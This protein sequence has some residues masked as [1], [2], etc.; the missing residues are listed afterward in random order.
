M[1]REAIAKLAAFQDIT[2]DE[3]AASMNEIMSGEATT[4]Q[5]GAFLA[6]MRMKGETS[7]EIIGCAR[8]MRE[9]AEPVR[10]TT[11]AI[12][13]VGTGGDGSNTFN[14][15]TCAAF[16]VAAAGMPVAKHG[17]RA[18]SSRC[19]SADGLEQLGGNIGLLPAQASECFARTGLCF[20]FAPVYHL[21]MKYAAAPR[22]ELG[23]RTIFNIL[24]PLANPAAAQYQL[25]G[26]CDDKLV[27]PMAQVLLDLG[28]RAAL[29]VHGH[30]GLDEISLSAPTTVCEVR[31]G[32]LNGYIIH[33]EQFGLQKAPL[34]EIVG[35]DAALNAQY[36][37]SVLKGSHGPRRDIVLLNA[38]ASLYIAGRA[39]TMKE[40]LRLAAEAI[41]S[42]AAMA[43]LELYKRVSNELAEA[44]A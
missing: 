42:G 29:S 22:R 21:S 33:P 44:S 13:I 34:A 5:I 16:V 1:I 7:A 12:D 18:V 23:M 43:K 25:L 19:G 8:V 26:V 10:L 28:V 35:G 27:E 2:A 4:A 36:V 24:G 15:S 14:I 41:D 6:A 3:A 11:D 39:A 9:K 31:N 37:L 40:G 38:G 17:N 32:R 30:D 20:L